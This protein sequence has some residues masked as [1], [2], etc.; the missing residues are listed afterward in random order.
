MSTFQPSH[1]NI[2]ANYKN[3]AAC[4]LIL[5]FAFSQGL[6]EQ[7]AFWPVTIRF[8]KP[9]FLLCVLSCFLARELRRAGMVFST[10]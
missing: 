7:N 8:V 2:A 4:I 9:G 1:R 10:Y 6:L 5:I 3:P